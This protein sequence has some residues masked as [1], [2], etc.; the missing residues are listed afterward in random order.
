MNKR[1]KRHLPPGDALCDNN[2]LLAVQSYIIGIHPRA[3]V[4]QKPH[5]YIVAFVL[6]VCD[7]MTQK[8]N[9]YHGML[10]MPDMAGYMLY[11][12]E[13][14]LSLGCDTCILCPFLAMCQLQPLNRVTFSHV[15]DNPS[16]GSRLSLCI[17]QL[18]QNEFI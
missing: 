15:Q 11:W 13:F 1:K 6:S 14:V 12:P 8:F 9:D 10:F 5:P 18:M 17:N 7:L 3:D 4:V 16:I 2:D